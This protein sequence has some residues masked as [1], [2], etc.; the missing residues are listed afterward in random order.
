MGFTW[1]EVS[2]GFT[3]IYWV[4]LSFHWVLLGF[5]GF[6]W[7]LMGFTGFYWVLLGFSGSNWVIIDSFF[8]EK[9]FHA[10]Y[11]YRV[12]LGLVPWTWQCLNGFIEVK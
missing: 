1:T 12:A 9:R 3:E 10:M 7:V 2:L 6:Y 5:S 8:S 4:S 11:L